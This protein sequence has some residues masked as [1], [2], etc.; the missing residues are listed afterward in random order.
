M[1]SNIVKYDILR[2]LFFLGGWLTFF[3]LVFF[4]YPPT[5]FLDLNE[6]AFSEMTAQDM[7]ISLSIDFFVV[8]FVVFF[9]S[10][11]VKLFYRA[12]FWRSFLLVF[13]FHAVW[14]I[15]LVLIVTI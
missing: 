7:L 4:A 12:S 11:L 9:Q 13:L 8:F 5:C 10:L 15:Y 1:I 2:G 14:V 3:V 6:K